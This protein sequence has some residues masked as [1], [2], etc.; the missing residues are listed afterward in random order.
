MPQRQ[1][2]DV[3]LGQI[4]QLWNAFSPEAQARTQLLQNQ[5]T[6]GPQLTAAQVAALQAETQARMANTGL[7]SAQTA[8][9]APT[10]AADI[11]SRNA[12]TELT[13]AQT[14]QVAPVAQ[15]Q[16]A[17]HQAAAAL[18]QA[19][20]GEVGPDASARRAELVAAIQAHLAAAGLSTA[21]TAQVAPT[22]AAQ[23]NLIVSETAKNT[24]GGV[25]PFLPQALQA[26]ATQAALGQMGGDF[27]TLPEALKQQKIIAVTKQVHDMIGAGK[28]HEAQMLIDQSGIDKS[29]FHDM[30]NGA[31]TNPDPQIAQLQKSLDEKKAKELQAKLFLHQQTLDQ[32]LGNDHINP[33]S[34]LNGAKLHQSEMKAIQD[35]LAK[36]P[37][38]PAPK[39]ALEANANLPLLDYII[40][41]WGL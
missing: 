12:G 2:Q 31:V 27:A 21:Q 17:M 19:Q 14:G 40:K 8:Q 25:I 1:K 15:S 23:K 39:N 10:A 16:I 9:V 34:R 3:D 11:A 18:S 36:L 24:V 35:Q 26:G 7:L 5:A 33:E 22:A 29:N 20:T 41:N 4:L 6:A 28:P 30:V 32:I 38:V 13:Q 37:N